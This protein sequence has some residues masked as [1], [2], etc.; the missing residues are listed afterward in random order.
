M[1]LGICSTA[2]QPSCSTRPVLSG[3]TKLKQCCGAVTIPV[4]GKME[5]KCGSGRPLPRP[6]LRSCCWQQLLW[7]LESR[8]YCPWSHGSW[9]LSCH[10]APASVNGSHCWNHITSVKQ[11][12][13]E[14]STPNTK[15]QAQLARKTS[16]DVSGW[17]SR[18]QASR[19]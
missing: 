8:E 3:S 11:Q 1:Q 16:W 9:S 12:G 19:N 14:R 18:R 13:K 5:G 6:G 2:K 4:T 15:Q 7:S 10:P 17:Y